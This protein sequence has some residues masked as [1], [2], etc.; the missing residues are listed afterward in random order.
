MIR[1]TIRSLTAAL[2]LL[3]LASTALAGS[4]PMLM[5]QIDTALNDPA[6]Q[7]RLSEEEREAAQELRDQGEE[8]HKSGDHAASEAALKQAKALL[9]IS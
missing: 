1:S 9:G 2:A 5:S 7:E 3:M 8:A 6:V 4:C